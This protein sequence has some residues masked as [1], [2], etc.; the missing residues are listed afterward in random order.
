[1]FSEL[2]SIIQGGRIKSAF[3]RKNGIFSNFSQKQSLK[4][5]NKEKEEPMRHDYFYYDG[6][7]KYAFLSVPMI[8]ITEQE[9]RKTTAD[10]KLLYA[11]MLNRANLSRKNGWIDALGRVFIYYTIENVMGDL[12]CANAKATKLMKELEGLDL[13]ERKRQGLG[14]PTIIY[15][16][17][18]SSHK[19]EQPAESSNA[20][21]A[22]KQEEEGEQVVEC[23]VGEGH[24]NK[25][26][27]NETL[28]SHESWNVDFQTH[29]NHDSESLII[30]YPDSL[31]SNTNK[32]DN[33]NPQNSHTDYSNTEVSYIEGNIPDHILSEAETVPE[34]EIVSQRQI[35]RDYFEKQLGYDA[36]IQDNPTEKDRIEEI[37]SLLVE[38]CASSKEKVFISGENKSIDEVR[39]VFMKLDMR[40]IQYVLDSMDRNT[41]RI[42]NIRQY[43]LAA[44]YNAPTTMYNYYRATVNSDYY[45]R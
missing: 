8:L 12:C 21:K 10:A 40:H 28:E 29:V 26:S 16:K 1:M 36:L 43:L 11:L 2:F 37:V 38:V 44:L 45:Q 6:A 34:R 9:Y 42:R 30:E 7:E 18:F 20:E 22:A 24:E 5:P 41:T 23:V 17:D 13:I 35:Y 19:D 33:N 27:E 14:K 25:E 3:F 31:N 39:Q 15:V 32:T 4:A